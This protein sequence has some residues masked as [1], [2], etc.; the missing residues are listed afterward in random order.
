MSGLDRL[1]RLAFLSI[2]VTLGVGTTCSMQHC[3]AQQLLNQDKDALLQGFDV[4]PDVL[5]KYPAKQQGT[6]LGVFKLLSMAI[7]IIDLD[8]DN[9]EAAL[10]VKAP[11]VKV[12]LDADKRHISVK[13]PFVKVDTSTRKGINVK[14]PMVRVHTSIDNGISIQTPVIKFNPLPDSQTDYDA[15]PAAPANTQSQFSP[16]PSPSSP[17]SPDAPLAVGTPSTPATTAGPTAP[18]WTDADPSALDDQ[19]H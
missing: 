5:A 19:I 3:Q 18:S 15:S 11:F 17:S 9:G 6:K 2:A 10:N 13:V 8:M 1:T 12:K 14:A 16:S 4:E 7:P